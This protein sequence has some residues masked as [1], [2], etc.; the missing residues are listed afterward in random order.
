MLA[1]LRLFPN[2]KV[3]CPFCKNGN[4]PRGYKPR[5]LR[6]HF[7]KVHSLG[8]AYKFTLGAIVEERRGNRYDIP[9][10]QEGQPVI[11]PRKRYITFII[12]GP[13]GCGCGAIIHYPLR[14]FTP[15]TVHKWALPDRAPPFYASGHLSRIQ[16]DNKGRF[17]KGI[18][19]FNKG[20]KGL[21]KGN[22]GSFTK[23]HQPANFNGG[24]WKPD[25]YVY[26]LIKGSCKLGASRYRS[27]ARRIAGEALGRPLT[28]NDVVLHLDGNPSNDDPKNLKVVTRAESISLRRRKLEAGRKISPGVCGRCKIL[29]PDPKGP[30]PRCGRKNNQGYAVDGPKP[31]RKPRAPKAPVLYGPPRPPGRPRKIWPPVVKGQ[32]GP[33][34]PKLALHR[35]KPVHA[36]P[37]FEANKVDSK[38]ILREKIEIPLPE[39]PHFPTSPTCPNCGTLLLG[40]QGTCRHCGPEAAEHRPPSPRPSQVR[41][42]VEEDEW[43][44]GARP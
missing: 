20:T 35:E 44:Q 32:K 33:N 10:L 22:P 27:R 12:E 5:K 15:A 16:P 30:C 36:P 9:L 31:A 39:K 13:C 25:G 2:G 4:Y 8:G 38:A 21:M 17:K 41:P 28:P 43:D 24:L 23:G 11:H 6:A 34:K 18:I 7:K 29:K 26:E 19:P 1:R 37:T 40:P 3:H 42:P 14:P